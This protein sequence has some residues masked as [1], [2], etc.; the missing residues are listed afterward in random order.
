MNNVKASSTAQKLL[1]LYR[2]AHVI[3][4]GW[5][6]VNQVF[7]AEASADVLAALRELPTGRSLV[8]HIENL[9]TGKTAMD[10]IERELLPYG[11]AMEI[12]TE[13]A[14][15]TT[16]QMRQL[17]DALNSF[18]PDENGLQALEN[19]AIIK[20]FGEEWL[21][22][23][24]A[25]LA[26]RPD[27]LAKWTTVTQTYQAYKLWNTANEVLQA[28]ISDRA[29]AQLQSDMPEYETYLPM[30]GDAGNELLARLRTYVSSIKPVQNQSEDTS[31]VTSSSSDVR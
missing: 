10:S 17:E 12:S 27:L 3:F 20:K 4:G 13:T 18:T 1:N 26:D 30:F 25:T 7:V 28:P 21:V 2:Q 19:T 15:L 11:G 6:A 22:G 9:R 23:V 16:S 5:G 31:A 24:R 8:R 14:P 29:R